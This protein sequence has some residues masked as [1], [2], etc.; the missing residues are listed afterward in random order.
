MLELPS[1]K[2]VPVLRLFQVQV[3][4]LAALSIVFPVVAEVSA[5]SAVVR[6]QGCIPCRCP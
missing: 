5:E 1:V 4:A 2:A 6:R 3:C